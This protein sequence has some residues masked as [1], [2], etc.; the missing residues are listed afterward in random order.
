MK[1]VI[2]GA[3]ELVHWL[4]GRYRLERDPSQVLSIERRAGDLVLMDPEGE[5]SQLV[6]VGPRQLALV[7][8]GNTAT[9]VSSDAELSFPELHGPAPFVELQ[10][11]GGLRL[12]A[13]RVPP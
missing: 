5:T 13:S 9:E 7:A 4:V 8:P 6:F 10:I 3:P 1:R 2:A 12:K 11:L